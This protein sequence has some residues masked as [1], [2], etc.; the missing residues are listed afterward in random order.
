MNSDGLV[1][2]MGMVRAGLGSANSVIF[3]DRNCGAFSLN[4]INI[5][6]ERKP[7][8]QDVHFG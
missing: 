6:T 7:W 4:R 5:M 1:E 3:P 2:V 8:S